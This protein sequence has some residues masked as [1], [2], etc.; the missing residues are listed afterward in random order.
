MIKEFAVKIYLR[1]FRGF[2]TA[3]SFTLQ[4]QKTVFVTSFADNSVY[5]MNTLKERVPSEEI[6]VLK[7]NKLSV[8]PN[9]FSDYKVYIFN[10]VKKPFEFIQ[11]IYHLATCRIIFIDNYFGFLA[12][13]PNHKKQLVV[14]LWHAAGA[15]KKFGLE[16]KQVKLRTPIAL[17]RFQ[18]A[19]DQVDYTVIGSDRM[20]ELFMDAFKTTKKQLLKTGIPRTD[21]FLNDLDMQKAKKKVINR[22][23]FIKDKKVILY[24]PTFRDGRLSRRRLRMDYKKIKQSI[25]DDYILLVKFHP[26][27]N[28]PFTADALPGFVYDVSAHK[29]VNELLTVVDL[30]I[31]DYSSLPFEFS[32]LKRPMVFYVPDLNRYSKSRGLWEPLQETVPGTIAKNTSELIEAINHASV[33]QKEFDAF[34]LRWNKYSDGQS[35]NDL[36]NIFYH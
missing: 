28:K 8:T 25:D 29:N 22:Y 27:L 13:M 10:D 15:I 17:E 34:N 5:V 18:Y 12:G 6:I 30:L 35:T 11:S 7:D 26:R 4:K 31:T 19:Y 20:G 36:I 2:F 23:P 1:I 14:Q 24:A 33:N 32:L 21:F 16:D 3:F 9:T